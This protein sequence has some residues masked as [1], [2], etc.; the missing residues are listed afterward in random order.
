MGH[1]YYI[2]LVFNTDKQAPD[3]SLCR[4]ALLGFAIPVNNVATM[5]E[6]DNQREQD[7]GLAAPNPV[8]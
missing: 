8:P 2:I 5:S 6:G 3:S 1:F 4:I 7:K